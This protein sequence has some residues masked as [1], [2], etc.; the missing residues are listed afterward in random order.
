MISWDEFLTSSRPHLPSLVASSLDL[1]EFLI[2]F[3]FSRAHCLQNRDLRTVRLWP[4]DCPP[5]GA[6]HRR[7]RGFVSASGADSLAPQERTVRHP[8]VSF[9]ELFHFIGVLTCGQSAPT[10]DSPPVIFQQCL[11]QMFYVVLTCGQSAVYPR[12]SAIVQ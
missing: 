7:L 11:E 8:P 9:P 4:A 5:I 10:P 2:R 12:L 3:G 6:E 1:I